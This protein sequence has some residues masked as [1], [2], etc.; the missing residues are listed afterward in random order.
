MFTSAN[1]LVSIAPELRF[2]TAI[3]LYGEQ[4]FKLFSTRETSI[5]PHFSGIAFTKYSLLTKHL[6][7]V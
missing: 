4:N 1:N 3:K 2:K 7:E 6:N 5:L